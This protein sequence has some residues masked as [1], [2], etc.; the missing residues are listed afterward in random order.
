MRM[1]LP[2]AFMQ[3]ESLAVASAN[4]PHRLTTLKILDYRPTG[5]RPQDQLALPGTITV[6]IGRHQNP[7]LQ[8]VREVVSTPDRDETALE[9]RLYAQFR[10]RRAVPLAE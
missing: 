5:K 4:R 9:H 6:L 3:L 8:Q 1:K 2:S 10:N 7:L